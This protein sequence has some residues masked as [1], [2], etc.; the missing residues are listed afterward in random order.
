MKAA[1]IISGLVILFLGMP[2]S[3]SSKHLPSGTVLSQTVVP[4][5]QKICGSIT[6]KHTQFPSLTVYG[7]YNNPGIA[8]LEYCQISEHFDMTGKLICKDCSFGSLSKLGSG[9]LRN[10]TIKKKLSSTG[11]TIARD[12]TFASFSGTGRALFDDTHVQGTISNTG[13]VNATNSKCTKLSVTGN[14][15]AKKLSCEEVSVT[16][17]TELTE[18]SVQGATHIVGKTTISDCLLKGVNVTGKITMKNSTADDVFITGK[19]QFAKTKMTSA[20]IT[21]R[22]TAT[23]TSAQ[24]CTIVCQEAAFTDCTIDTLHIKKQTGFKILGWTFFWSDNNPKITV[25]IYNSPKNPEC[26]IKRIICDAPNVTI[27]YTG[28]SLTVQ[29]IIGTPVTIN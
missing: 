5:H 21:G 17:K 11:K 7:D 14:V 28:D 15:Q 26:V 4:N 10:V 13:K 6:A 19:A 16:G 9:E 12:C 29:E 27:R 3:C 24:T 2:F 23:N 18:T 25:T 20:Q 1:L 22:L 8:D